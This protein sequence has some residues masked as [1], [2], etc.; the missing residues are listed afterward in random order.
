MDSDMVTSSRLTSAI[1]YP[2]KGELGPGQKAGKVIEEPRFRTLGVLDKMRHFRHPARYWVGDLTLS[3][4]ADLRQGGDSPELLVELNEGV[5]QYRSRFDL[6]TGQVQIFMI[7][8]FLADQEERLLAT[9]ETSVVMG[10]E[11]DIRFANVDNRLCLWVDDSLISFDE[12]LIYDSPGFPGPRERDRVPVGI[13]ARGT[14]LTVSN[15]LLQRDIYYRAEIYRTNRGTPEDPTISGIGEMDL[16]DLYTHRTDPET[17]WKLYIHRNEDHS[18]T[19]AQLS[20]DE[21][22]VM[23]DNSPRSKDSRLWENNRG[24]LHRHAVNE[25]ALV[26]KAFFIFWPHGIPFGNNGK[27]YPIRYHRDNLNNKT[28]YP[29]YTLPFYP[30]IDKMKRI[31]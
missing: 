4:H 18:I 24:A 30:Q 21:Y 23:G 13:A 12:E 5:R 31:R 29:T 7:D 6:Q 16:T 2:V 22:F 25:S 10:D 11:Y 26:G 1:L 27:G 28:D 20:E 3:F 19:F 14:D 15:L 17:W 9:A 8:H